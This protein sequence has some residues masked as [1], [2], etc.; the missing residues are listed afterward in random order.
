VCGSTAHLARDCPV[1]A[2]AGGREARAAAGFA[3]PAL[4]SSRGDFTRSKWSHQV[5]STANPEDLGGSSFVEEPIKK[6]KGDGFGGESEGGRQRK[7]K[8][9][10]RYQ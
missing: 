7:P 4:A 2:A 9:D 5:S 10:L 8:G 1:E 3:A 6:S